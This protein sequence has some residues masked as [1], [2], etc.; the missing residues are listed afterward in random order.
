MR[1]RN[2]LAAWSLVMAL[3]CTATLAQAGDLPAIEIPECKTPPILNGQ[4]DDACW[5]NA[6]K[7]ENLHGLGTAD[8]H[9][10]TALQ[11]NVLCEV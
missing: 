4:I 11:L 1:K 6:V 9:T 3:F 7:V 5:Q 8:G 10:S 2:C